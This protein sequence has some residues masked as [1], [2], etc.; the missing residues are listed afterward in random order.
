MS[1]SSGARKF[2]ILHLSH[3]DIRFDFR[4]LRSMEAGLSAGHDV[5]GFGLDSEMGPNPDLGN[6]IQALI[7]SVKRPRVGAKLRAGGYSTQDTV[8][9]MEVARIRGGALNKFVLAFKSSR[10]FIR[11]LRRF[12]PEIIHLHDAPLMPLAYG[13]R[14]F[15]R[16][17]IVYDAHE[18]GAERSGITWAVRLWTLFWERLSWPV[19]SGFITVSESIRKTYEDAYGPLRSV[20]V[21]NMYSPIRPVGLSDWVQQNARVDLGLDSKT[22]LYTYVGAIVEGRMLEETIQAFSQ[23]DEEVAVLMIL[24]AGVK[25]TELQAIPQRGAIKFLDPVPNFALGTFLRGVDY[26]FCLLDS[27]NPNE[28]MAL[29]NK[30]FEYI[31]AGVRPICSDFP[32][33]SA[34]CKSSGGVVW[35][36]GNVSQRVALQIAEGRPAGAPGQYAE[37]FSWKSEMERLQAFYETVW[38]S[39]GY[40][41]GRQLP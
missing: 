9:R 2:R 27:H 35:S 19:L 39:T 17:L 14:I 6:A 15:F 40:R 23:V 12:R 31:Y 29:P 5:R 22:L 28:F 30:L 7:T 38:L 1:P 32:E 21:R 37:R 25:S 24:G 11:E 41:E 18:L 8:R 4:I 20:V 33:M 10:S 16:A 13:A 3:S 34:I 26:G 36:E